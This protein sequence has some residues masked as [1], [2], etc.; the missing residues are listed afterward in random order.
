MTRD[1]NFDIILVGSG[2]MGA[3]IAYNLIKQNPELAIALVER[4][5]T[6][7]RSSTVMSDG[8]VRIQF[9]LPA[10]IEIS[11]YGFKM[12]ETFADDMAIEGELP[13]DFNFR[14]QGNI[15][16][17]DEKGVPFALDGL[18]VQKAH[19]CDVRWLDPADV[20]DLYP[21][22]DP[23]SCAGGTFGPGD[24][25]MSPLDI[26][27]GYRKKALALGVTAVNETVTDF[28]AADG[29]MQGVRL[30]S[31]QELHSPIVVST[32]GVWATDL[33]RQIGVDL[34][35]KS[36]KRETYSISGPES[37]DE[38]LPMLLLPTGQYLLHEGGNHFLTGG[39]GPNDPETTTD[40][41]WSKAR[42]EE[43]FW[44][45]LI[46]FIPSFDRLKLVNGWSGL[47]AINHFD[48][49]AILGEW[50]ELKG[51][52][53]ANGFSG[54]GF[55]QCHGVGRYISDLI[56]G[57]SLELDLSIFSPVRILENAPVFENPARLI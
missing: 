54:H 57:S 48:G 14:K 26:L 32:T 5:T 12:L 33:L 19:D 10:N 25:T 16:I 9:N 8:N 34:P 20:V 36:I 52:Y 50:P 13:V 31:G 1:T 47:Y 40:F 44:E 53:L 27:M 7:Q 28:L 15:F 39:A 51:L 49:N 22:F 11:K 55:Q 18:K 41:G 4:D 29:A 30:A 21:I 2:C 37:F 24:G 45:R 23:N 6:F 56:L 17:S 43:H 35:I 42:F 38:I 3:A 46:Y